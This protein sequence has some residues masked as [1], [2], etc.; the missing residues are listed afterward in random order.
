MRPEDN[1]IGDQSV[2]AG[3]V[4]QIHERLARKNG[5][6]PDHSAIVFC[7]EHPAVDR[8]APSVNLL[9]EAAAISSPGRNLGSMVRSKS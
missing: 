6:E 4:V 8:A 2:R 3:R 5:N 9:A 1:E 7:N